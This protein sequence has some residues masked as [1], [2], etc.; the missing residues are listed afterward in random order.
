MLYP[1]VQAR[2]EAEAAVEAAPEAAAEAGMTP[3]SLCSVALLWPAKAKACPGPPCNILSAKAPGQ[4]AAA[5]QLLGEVQE[6]LMVTAK[7]PGLLG[8]VLLPGAQAAGPQTPILIQ[9]TE[10]NKGSSVR[11]V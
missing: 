3:P 6:P 2:A 4:S 5:Q 8:A 10:R 1:A 9:P 7:A 11:P